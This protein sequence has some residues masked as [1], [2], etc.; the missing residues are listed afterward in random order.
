[1][2]LIKTNKLNKHLQILFP[3]LLERPLR[4][5]PWYVLKKKLYLI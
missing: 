3:T 2:H 1:M 4:I 5:E